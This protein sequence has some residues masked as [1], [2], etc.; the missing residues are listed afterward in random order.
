MITMKQFT[1]NSIIIDFEKR[2]SILFSFE[3]IACVRRED[4]VYINK[5]LDEFRSSVK[6]IVEYVKSLGVPVKKKY[7]P[8]TEMKKAVSIL[9]T[10][11]YPVGRIESF[12]PPEERALYDGPS[13]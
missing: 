6:H 8:E 9:E 13:E 11:V 10:T 2:C 4:V 1:R 12:E 7:V 3:R 5:D